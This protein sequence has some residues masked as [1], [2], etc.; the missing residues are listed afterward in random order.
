MVPC[1]LKVLLLL[2]HVSDFLNTGIYMLHFI[3]K[4]NYYQNIEVLLFIA[5]KLISCNVNHF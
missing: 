1:Q 4:W 5:Q 2:N 3:Q